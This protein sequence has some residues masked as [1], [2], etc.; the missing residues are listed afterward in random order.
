MNSEDLDKIT[1][2]F[3]EKLGDESYAL[4]SD[5]IGILL[6][7]N[8]ETQSLINKKDEDIRSLTEKNEKLV[9]ANGSLL[10]QVSVGI[11]PMSKDDDDDD[12]QK[13]SFNFKDA[14][15]EKGRFKEKM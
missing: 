6:T 11:D 14:F 15:D 8:S 1:S 3:K 2:S 9:K 12:S 5:D 4:I 7:K 10:Q 13:K